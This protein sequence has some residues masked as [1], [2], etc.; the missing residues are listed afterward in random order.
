MSGQPRA[1]TLRWIRSLGGPLLLLDRSWCAAWRGYPDDPTDEAGTDYERACGIAGPIGPIA[2]G[3]GGGL[4]VADGLIL[5]TWVPAVT[6]GGCIIQAY[7]DPGD[8][9]LL[10]LLSDLS[11]VMWGEGVCAIALPTG[12]G[13]LFDA[14]DGGTRIEA[15]LCLALAP[16][17]YQVHTAEYAPSAATALRLHRLTPN[18]AI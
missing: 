3:S 13:F 15:R 9:E 2:I 6:G 11:P 8:A 18:T 16:G 5:T 7:R 14:A 1:T 4:V 10:A 17:R 12:R